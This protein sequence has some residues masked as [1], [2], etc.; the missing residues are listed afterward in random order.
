MRYVL[1]PV[2][3]EYVL[4]VMRWVLFRAPEGETTDGMRDEAR[5]RRL[6]LE[7]EPLA[8]SLLE[9]VARATGK[10]TT[11]RLSDAAD[12]LEQEPEVVRATLRELNG[13]ALGGGR[14][15]VRLT[16]ETAVRVNGNTGQDVCLEMRAEH[17]SAIRALLR[18]PDAQDG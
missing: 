8:R 17:A 1:V 10:G 3:T 16:K 11:L 15:L 2:P 4:D 6:V 18:S 12:E 13:S 14:D 7:A 9:L 5:V